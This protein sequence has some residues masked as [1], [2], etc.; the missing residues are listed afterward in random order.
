MAAGESATRSQLLKPLRNRRYRALISGFV[1]SG[2]G[3]ALYAP[4]LNWYVLS[5]WHSASLLG[6]FGGVALAGS[7]A[8]GLFNLWA[9]DRW[10]RG[11]TI[12]G[13]E[14]G[15][16]VIA[17]ALGAVAAAGGPAWLL[18]GLALAVNAGGMVSGP[19]YMAWL[20]DLV[21]AEELRAVN[22]L[23][24]IL[25]NTVDMVGRGLSG[26]LIGLVGAVALML[27]NAASFL[28][29]ALGAAAARRDGPSREGTRATVGGGRQGLKEVALEILANVRLRNTVLLLAWFNVGEG[30]FLVLPAV[31][32]QQ[33]FHAGSWA[34]GTLEGALTIGAIAGAFVAGSA[35]WRW[36]PVAGAMVGAAAT[37]LVPLS[38]NPWQAGALFALSHAAAA[39]AGI[40]LIAETQTLTRPEIRARVFTLLDMLGVGVMLPASAALAG[41]VAQQHGRAVPFVGSALVWLSGA[42]V[43]WQWTRTAGEPVAHAVTGGR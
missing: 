15:R 10:E 1:L 32:V 29:S 4:A 23:D 26:V 18:A 31:L 33:R 41:I 28:A 11:G 17:L 19:S 43:L 21:K 13:S 6:L 14:L 39:W 20:P 27:L 38:G 37:A 5:R 8:G 2:F 25:M 40:T 12:I 36:G 24:R 3:T 35:R 42:L 34:M 7:L 9:G 22:A 30:P 16:G